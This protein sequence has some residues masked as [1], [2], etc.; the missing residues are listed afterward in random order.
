MIKTIIIMLAFAAAFLPLF[1]AGKNIIKKKSA[2][3][4]ALVINIISVLGLCVLIFVISAAGTVMAAD[5]TSAGA[6]G[7]AG[8]QPAAAGIGDKGIGMIAAALTMGIS[9]IG[10]GIAVASSAS[11]AIGAISENPKVFGQALIFVV[12]GEGIALYGLLISF[13]ILNKF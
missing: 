1:L 10:G 7:A 8:V 3:K 6:V 13:M 11:A 4:A 12:L 2:K 5:N 9:G